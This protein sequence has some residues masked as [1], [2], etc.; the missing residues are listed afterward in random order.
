MFVEFVIILPNGSI[1]KMVMVGWGMD[2]RAT[3]RVGSPAV[4]G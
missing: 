2:I 3:N 1:L 4:E